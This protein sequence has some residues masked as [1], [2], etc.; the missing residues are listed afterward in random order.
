MASPKPDP[1]ADDRVSRLKQLHPEDIGTEAFTQLLHE[2]QVHQEELTAQN[3]QLLETQ[4]ALEESR[5]RYVDLYDFAP[6]GFMTMS[7]T[8]IIREINLTGAA[9][10][11]GGPRPNRRSSVLR[12]RLA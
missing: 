1:G 5:D 7:V 6:I 9:L 3:Q 11:G 10:R 4:R 12:I 2:L 8:G